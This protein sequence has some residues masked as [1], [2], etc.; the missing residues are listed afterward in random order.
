MHP[1]TF[2]ASS[3]AIVALA[4]PHALG[5]QQAESLPIGARVRVHPLTPPLV[6]VTGVLVRADSAGLV[7]AGRDDARL[8]SI[9]VREVS[10]LERHVFTRPKGSAFVRGAGRG[11]LVG[12]ALSAVL[13]GAAV[14]EDR[15]NSCHDCFVNAR[16][17]AAVVAVPLTAVSSLVGGAVGLST[18]ERWARVAY[19]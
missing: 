13:V 6:P 3:F 1:R 8:R 4:L 16:L 11:A 2:V 9:P 12:L 19:P 5:A 10:R 7:I 17:A 15:R 18:R 14:V